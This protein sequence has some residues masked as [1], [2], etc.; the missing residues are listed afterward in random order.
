MNQ[1]QL[2]P[3]IFNEDVKMESIRTGFGRGLKAAAEANDKIVAL[4][5]DLTDSTQVGLFRD[6]FPDRFI[7]TG[8]SEQ[9]LQAVNEIFRP[10][11]ALP[12]KR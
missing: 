4:C 12:Y 9:N 10:S 3:N 11:P 6:A 8:I 2:N 7:E 1:Y 5:A